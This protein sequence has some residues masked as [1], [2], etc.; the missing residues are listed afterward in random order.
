M[1]LSEKQ[2]LFCNEYLVDLNATQAAIRAK[3]SVDTAGAIGHENLTKPE[4]KARISELRTEMGIGFNITRERIAQE[5]AR[6]AFFDIRKV[7]DDDGE[8]IPV[9]ELDQDTA[10]ALAGI[11]VSNEWDRDTD[12]K[13]MIVGQLKKIKISDK[14]A[15]LD[16]L[17]K[18]MGFNEPEKHDFKGIFQQV[19]GMKFKD[20]T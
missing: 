17:C 3:Y 13:V 11:E 12:G 5:Y 9:K 14:R 19:T 15:A 4:I 10:L 20:A 16:S 7:Y 1:A 8:L 2:E 18:L 6:I